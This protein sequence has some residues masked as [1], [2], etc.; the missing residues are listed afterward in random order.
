MAVDSGIASWWKLEGCGGVC[1]E[2][3][4]G[5]GGAGCGVVCYVAGGDG[6]CVVG[7]TEV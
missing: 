7:W 2:I 1:G 6:G 5:V 3:G 4:A